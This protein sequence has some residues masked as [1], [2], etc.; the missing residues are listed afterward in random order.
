MQTDI[1]PRSL[2]GRKAVDRNGTKIGT[3]DEVYLDDATGAPEWAA[4]RTGVFSRDALVPL[5]PSE[6]VD[7]ALRVPFER[8]LIREA[9]DFGAGRHLSPEQELAL[10]QHYGLDVP[11]GRPGDP[12]ADEDFGRLAPDESGGEG[13]G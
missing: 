8:T 10:Y 6:L 2:I 1:D 13:E 9:P 4:V 7:D 5:D 12:P 11:G 3:V